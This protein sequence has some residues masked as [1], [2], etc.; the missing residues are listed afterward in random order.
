M[1]TLLAYTDP[2]ELDVPSDA[3]RWDN[4][5]AAMR[6][7]G[8]LGETLSR[9][10]QWTNKMAARR[11]RAHGGP[12]GQSYYNGNSEDDDGAYASAACTN[13]TLGHKFSASSDNM[14]T[15]A[16]S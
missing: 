2:D 8:P 7:A 12:F 1:P 4:R 6:A 3:A 15:S 16:C 10:A 9:D 5:I 13:V 11:M 14:T